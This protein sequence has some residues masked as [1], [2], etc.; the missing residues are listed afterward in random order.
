MDSTE[1]DARLMMCGFVLDSKYEGWDDER[2]YDFTD[3]K[4]TKRG[5]VTSPYRNAVHPAVTITVHPAD[6]TAVIEV[7]EGYDE[8]WLA[9][10][11]LMLDNYEEQV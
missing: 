4:G 11:D 3:K 9:V 6:R 10:Q 7:S 5:W 2:I 1:F 8:A